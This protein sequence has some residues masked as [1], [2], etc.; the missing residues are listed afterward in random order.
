MPQR[1]RR[2]TSIGSGGGGSNDAKVRLVEPSSGCNGFRAATRIASGVSAAA[3]EGARRRRLLGRQ[4]LLPQPS[5]AGRRQERQA[6]NPDGRPCPNPPDRRSGL[7]ARPCRKGD[8]RGETPS[9]LSPSQTVPEV[10]PRRARRSPTRSKIG[11]TTHEG[12]TPSTIHDVT[13]KIR[14][15]NASATKSRFHESAR[16]TRPTVAQDRRKCHSACADRIWRRGESNSRPRAYRQ[17]VYK[18]RLPFRFARRP[19]GNR[20]TAGLVIL[21]CRASGDDI[22]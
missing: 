5:E 10:L 22:P 17:S 4:T 21:W 2:R 15:R 11:N 16:R 20:P 14:P 3:E 8:G 19:V 6:T 12:V 1:Q 13:A 18:L 7:K 9:A